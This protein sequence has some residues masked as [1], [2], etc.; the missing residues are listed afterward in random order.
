MWKLKMNTNP[1][2]SKTITLSSSCLQLTNP[3]TKTNQSIN[4]MNKRIHIFPDTYGI[5]MQ[6]AKMFLQTIHSDIEV[7]EIFVLEQW[8]V[9]QIPL[10]S[11]VVKRVLV[12]F[13]REIQPFRMAKFVAY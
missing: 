3:F 10:A 11:C 13:S 2:R 6:P 8:I 4:Q 12:A 5:F 1:A 7:V 9:H